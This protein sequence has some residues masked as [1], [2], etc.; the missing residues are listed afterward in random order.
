MNAN[1]NTPSVGHRES[2]KIII[3]RIINSFFLKKPYSQ[4]Y[5]DNCP[6]P[7]LSYWSLKG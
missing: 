5:I 4:S 2:I 1:P 6:Y 3:S 7:T